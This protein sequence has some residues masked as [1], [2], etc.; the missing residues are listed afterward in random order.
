MAEN[1][2]IQSQIESLAT[3]LVLEEEIR[4]LTNVRELGFFATNETHRLIQ[5]HTSYLWQQKEFIGTH[6]IAQSGTAEIDIHAP[7]NQWLVNKIDEIRSDDNARETHQINL[8]PEGEI[9][10]PLETDVPEE[11]PHYLLWCP[12]LSKSNQVTGG[13]V[14]FRETPFSETEI[15]MLGWLIASYQNMWNIL[16]KPN[17]VPTLEQL[18]QKPYLYTFLFLFI[19]LLF[20]PVHLTVFGDGTVIPKDPIL[21][22]APMQGVIQSFEVNPGDNV[23]KGQILLT[24][25]KTEFQATAEVNKKDYLLTEAKLR[26]ATNQ[27][28]QN[29]DARS[30]IPIIAAQLAI[31]KANLDYSN[32]MLAKTDLISPINGV[33]IFDS[34]EDWVGQPVKTGERIMV[35]SDPRQVELKISLPIA[36]AIELQP[37]V[38][39]EFF[40]YG[41]LNS[42]PVKIKTLGYNAK[43]LPNKILAYQLTGAFIHLKTV[44]QLGAQGTVKI[45]GHYVPFIYYVVRR[46]LQ[47]MRQTLGI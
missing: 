23:K 41:H 19:C 2:A 9:A 18:K 20:F 25:N 47:V 46:P 11:L 27:G 28:F 21:I 35:V 36:S 24:L 22:N 17:R 42:L 43:L 34:K 39:A 38:D 10:I 32:E 15:K 29:K 44:P 3:L 4:K 8:T 30:D 7:A 12:L 6:L 26:S 14:F 13:L 33:V 31:D 37:G 5:F 16:V 40:P 45:Y 1:V